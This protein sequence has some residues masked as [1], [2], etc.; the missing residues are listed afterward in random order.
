M[1]AIYPFRGYRYNPEKVKDVGMVFAEPYDKIT[2]E[3]QEKYYRRHPHNIVR[4][5]K[6]KTT[7]QDS[8]SDNQY[9]R[10]RAFL[11]ACIAEGVL[12]REAREALYVYEQ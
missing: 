7:A 6:G 11:D 8:P 12:V 5:S 4:F 10:A 2:P 3:L 1:A 9:T